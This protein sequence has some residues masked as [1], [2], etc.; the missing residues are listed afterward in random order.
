MMTSAFDDTARTASAFD[1]AAENDNNINEWVKF[2]NIRE[3]NYSSTWLWQ[4]W[5]EESRENNSKLTRAYDSKQRSQMELKQ[6]IRSG[7]PAS[8]R[9][10]K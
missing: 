1:D 9:Y 4:Y 6:L 7:I 2:L 10:N 8:Y 5:R 3:H